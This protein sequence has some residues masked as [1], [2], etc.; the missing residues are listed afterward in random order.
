MLSW[1]AKRSCVR[2]IP[3]WNYDG[4]SPDMNTSTRTKVR[5]A[6]FLN[7]MCA[8]CGPPLASAQNAPP[9]CAHAASQAL[10]DS[11]DAY[12]THVARHVMHYNRGFTFG[13]QVP[14]IVPAIVVLRI[15]VDEDGNL[16][17]VAVQ[18]SRD[19]QASAVALASMERSGPLPKPVSLLA[20]D[21]GSLTF[22]ETFLFNSNYQFQ[23]RS[24][25]EP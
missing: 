11:V 13:G 20:A 12:K 22:L 17:S 7:L 5:S 23:L 6:I 21:E 8:L 19:D 3:V 16:I 10:F 1:W 2:P 24:L 9:L 14:P 4:F 25:V 18:R 15:T